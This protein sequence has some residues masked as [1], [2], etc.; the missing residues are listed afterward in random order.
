MFSFRMQDNR[1][2]RKKNEN[3]NAQIYSGPCTTY[4]FKFVF[5]N[6]S[7]QLL[8]PDKNMFD[9]QIVLINP[10]RQPVHL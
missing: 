6:E 7:S 10:Q 4:N 2:Y 8:E 3:E 5:K 1:F 9:G